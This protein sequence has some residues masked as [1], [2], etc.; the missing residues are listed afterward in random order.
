MISRRIEITPPPPLVKIGAYASKKKNC[1]SL[2]QGV[3]YYSPPEELV[4]KV[5]NSNN[6]II[7]KYTADNGMQDLRDSICQKYQD[8]FGINVNS[9][10]VIITSGCNQAFI[11]ILISITDP[12]DKIGLIS[13]YY[14]NHFMAANFLNV[15]ALEIKLTENYNL[16]LNSIE[17][18]MK[19]GI[20]AIVLVNPSNPTG[21]VYSESEIKALLEL[22]EKYQVILIADETYE[23]FTYNNTFHTSALKYGNKNLTVILGSFSKTFGIPGWR[24]GY[25]I[26]P[27]SLI[28]QSM[29]VQDTIPICASSISQLLGIE[30]IDNRKKLIPKFVNQMEKNYK[31][32]ID[33]LE[34]IK[35]LEASPSSGAYYIFPKHNIQISTSKLAYQ[36]IDNQ[37][38]YL[39]PGEGFGKYATNNFRISFAN[40]DIP[41]LIEAFDRLKKFKEY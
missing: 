37:G 29:K 12:G 31:T 23:Y 17:K 2:G 4:L 41:T 22:V 21:V 38:V 13:P 16:D 5:I 3:P 28:D 24:L 34:E 20:K 32:S 7:H 27:E 39:V 10:Q 11:N 19:Q 14:F 33:L 6:P 36:L 40:V 25:Y 26:A 9:N 35:W 30:L 15:E 18:T 8:D 1:I